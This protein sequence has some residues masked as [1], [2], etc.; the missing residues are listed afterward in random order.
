[1]YILMLHALIKNMR[2][3]PNYECIDPRKRAMAICV[4]INKIHISHTREP[5]TTITIGT[6]TEYQQEGEQ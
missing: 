2:I 3:R 4:R 1:M 5:Y 6:E